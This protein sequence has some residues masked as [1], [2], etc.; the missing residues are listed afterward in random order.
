MK[1]TV[2]GVV[3]AVLLGLLPFI[4]SDYIFYGAVN[5]KLFFI[6]GMIDV[7]LIWGAWSIFQG[8][9]KITLRRSWFLYALT[10]A[11]FIFYVSAIL[12]VYPERSLW[13]DILRGTGLLFLTH[14]A[15]FAVLVGQVF[16][17]RDWSL[18]RRT[19]LV[20]SGVFGFL[21]IFGK[22]GFGFSG[23]FLWINLV[24]QGLTFGNGTF[25]GVYLLLAFILGLIEVT[26][27]RG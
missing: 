18:L 9:I 25:A 24:E 16:T 4:N 11:L 27:L 23:D 8:S 1:V 15:L 13:S 22:N 12:G 19:I 26:R 7:F 5:T 20:S 2:F 14:L 6:I 21:T 10:A 3:A 17:E